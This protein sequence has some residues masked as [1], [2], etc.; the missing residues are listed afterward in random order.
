MVEKQIA[1]N[2]LFLL[3]GSN[4]LPNFL[5]TLILKP[6]SVRFFYSP[7]TEDVKDY[8][9]ERLRIKLAQTSQVETCIE[10]ATDAAKVKD[11]F[12][13]VPKGTHL[14]Y[15]GGTKIMAAH[16]RMAFFSGRGARRTCLV[17]R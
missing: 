8:L 17:P 1:C 5:A 13:S 16:A 3:V 4:P 2:D 9:R 11:A 14:H 6:K 15:T 12:A 10:D 7:E